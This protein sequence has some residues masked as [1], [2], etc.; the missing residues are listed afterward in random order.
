MANEPHRLL[1][2]VD[3]PESFL[4]FVDALVADRIASRGDSSATGHGATAAWENTTI[5]SFLDS[6]AAWAR[7]SQLGQTQGLG[8]ANPWRLFATFLYCGKIYE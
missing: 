7:D 1:E 8:T 5:E 6:A 3:G 2:Q 4:K